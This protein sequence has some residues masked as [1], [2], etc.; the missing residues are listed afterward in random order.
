MRGITIRTYG[1]IIV[2]IVVVAAIGVG[3]WYVTKAPAVEKEITIAWTE[4]PEFDFIESKLPE[5]EAATGITVN[6]EVIPRAHI[7][8]RLMLEIISPTGKIDGSVLYCTELPTVAATAGLVNLYDYKPKSDWISEGFYQSQLETVE[9]GGKL[10]IVP[11]LWNGALLLYY[12]EEYF[13]NTEWKNEFMAWPGR[14]MPELKVPENPEELLEVAKFFHEKA[15]D[16]YAIHLQATT[17][18]MGAGGYCLYPPL[19]ADF[20]GGV[21]NADTGEI[22][23]NK[24][25]SVEA[26]EYLCELVKYAQPTVLTDGTFEAQIAIL[27]G[28]CIM[29]DQW[30]YMVPMLNDPTQSKIPGKMKVAMR[31]FGQMPDMLGIA[32]LNT[33]K[34]DLTWEFVEW[35]CSEEI[36]LGTT[37]ACPKASCRSDVAANPQV[38]GSTWINPILDSY[39]RVQHICPLVKD[40]RIVE[41]YDAMM[42]HL[43]EAFTGAKT[44]QEAC[45]AAA[46][47]IQNIVK[48]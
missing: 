17:E 35:T 38:S 15:P 32:I 1:I 10:H 2:V 41:I 46:A 42:Y 37:L 30:S 5:F 27:E 6:L 36:V 48:A 3:A 20:G 9:I 13:E 14:T 24:P 22:L 39:G 28:R 45:D 40:P 23:I 12:W 26:M 4:G 11:T 29:A 31:P 25:E 16:K 8:E 47:D 19:A 18:E 21:Y 44:P 34:K 7:V 43:G 33:P